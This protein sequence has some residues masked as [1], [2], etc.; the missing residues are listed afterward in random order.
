MNTVGQDLHLSHGAVSR[1][2]LAVAGPG[3][4]QECRTQVP[5]GQQLP[6]GQIIRTSGHQLSCTD[7]LHGA[8]DKWDDGA[9][10]CE[11]VVSLQ[12]YNRLYFQHHNIGE[13][14]TNIFICPIAM[15]GTDYKIGLRL[16]V[17]QCV[18]PSASTLTVAFL[19]RF[20]PKLAQT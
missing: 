11:K 9:G 5:A 7:V 10:S 17:C 8:C 18:C 4:Q 20:S 14:S 1:S 12:C 2:V 16:S 15:H 19:D 6:L 3:I 13:I